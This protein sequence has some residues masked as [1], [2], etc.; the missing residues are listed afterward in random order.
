MRLITIIAAVLVLLAT[1][2]LAQ[3]GRALHIRLSG[4]IDCRKMVDELAAELAAAKDAAAPL[5]ILEIDGRGGRDDLV[6]LLARHIR[7]C[8]F[9][10]AAYLHPGRGGS[11]GAAQAILAVAATTCYIAP[12]ASIAAGGEHELRWLAPPDTDWELIQ[13]E[14]GALIST[15]LQD[16]SADP[17]LAHILVA[18]ATAAWIAEIDGHPTLL[19]EPPQNTTASTAVQIAFTG[20]EGFERL[21]ITS[22]LALQMRIAADTATTIAQIAGTAG[23]SAVLPPI[24]R[25]RRITSNLAAARQEAAGTLQAMQV[26]VARIGVEL[27][28]KKR[29]KRTITASDYRQAGAKALEMAANVEDSIAKIHQCLAEY[30][31]LLQS[32]PHHGRTSRAQP[33]LLSKLQAVQRD[34]DKLRITAEEYA[35][36]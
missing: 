10:I 6:W 9:P 2:T 18:P 35:T 32:R 30:P 8:P 3:P 19:T 36:R 33:E 25:P 28:L 29:L 21:H 7:E 16:R 24:G 20:I 17:A 34:L 26:T 22:T 13:R 5:V 12:H 31:E 14:L 4:P 27:D 15:A 11:V 23:P 1:P